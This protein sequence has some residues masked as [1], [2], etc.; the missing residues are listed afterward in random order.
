M[1]ELYCKLGEK[2]DFFVDLTSGNIS[3][4]RPNIF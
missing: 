2:N 4:F 1:I 3:H